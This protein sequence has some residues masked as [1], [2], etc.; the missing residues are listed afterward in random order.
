MQVLR[1][2]HRL[3]WCFVTVALA[4]LASGPVQQHEIEVFCREEGKSLL[5]SP[6]KRHGEALAAQAPSERAGGLCVRELDD[7]VSVAVVRGAADAVSPQLAGESLL[8]H[9]QARTQALLRLVDDLV[10]VEVV[11]AVEKELVDPRD[12]ILENRAIERRVAGD[13]QHLERLA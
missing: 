9:L 2:R 1:N 3:G 7:A 11:P 5:A 6:C 10:A 8:R 4:E 12:A 13:V